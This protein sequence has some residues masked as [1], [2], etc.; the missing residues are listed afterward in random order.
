MKL[1]LG[2]D[3]SERTQATA[4]EEHR[5]SRASQP[6]HRLLPSIR[7]P[8]G[9]AGP[10]NSSAGE[11]SSFGRRPAPGAGPDLRQRYL[12]R[13]A[14]RVPVEG[15]G[16]DRHL[17]RIHGPSALSRMD[18]RRGVPGAVA[19]RAGTLRRITGSGLELAEHGR[20]HDQIPLGR[21]KKPVPI[22]RTG[23][24]AASNAVC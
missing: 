8:V 17:L 9:G 20:G 14:H 16:C 6:H 4:T 12:L 18:R 24:R 13:A 3:Q 11:H 2:N 21:G 5:P 19:D 7:R 22:P 23:V 15:V 10:A 1:N